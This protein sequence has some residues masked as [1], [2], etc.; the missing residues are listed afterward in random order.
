VKLGDHILPLKRKPGLRTLKA[1][2]SSLR[3]KVLNLLFDKGPQ[4]YTEIMKILRLD[5]SRDAGRFAYHLKYLLKADLIEPD[6]ET[7]EYCIT[8]LGKTVIGFTEDIEERFFRRKKMLVRT[9]R[10]A[11]EE[12]DRNKIAES[13]A[14]EAGVPA[15][16]AQKIARET[17]KRLLEFKTKYLT[18]PLIREIVNS[19]LIKKGLEEYR[20][21]LTRLGLPVFDVTQIIKSTGSKSLGVEVVHK[22]AGDAVIE[23]FTLLN[24]LPRD[25]ADA[26]LSGTLHLNNL[27]SWIL[28]PNEFMH[29]LR[30][31][32]QRGLNLGR[33]DSTG[34]SCLPPKSLESALLTASNALQVAATEISVEQALDFFNIFLAPFAQGLPE[35]RIKKGLRLFVFDLNQSF[36][37]GGFPVA[38]SLGIEFVVPSFLRKREAVG[39]SGKKIG[40][41]ED[42]VEESR[43][44]ASLLLEI[45]FE[46]D[47]HK[48]V[49][50]PSLI[51]KIRPEVLEN[52]EC[53]TLLFQSHKLAAEK[54]LPCFANLCF[55]DQKHASYTAKGCR[56]ASD[57]KRDWEL[58]TL[59]TGNIGKV[60]INLPRTSY[61][62][63][64]K[65]TRFFELL[66]ERLEM[67]LRALEIK[68]RTIKQR[69]G[70]TLLPFLT[71]KAD[72]DNYFKLENASRLVSFVGLSETIESFSGKA[73]HQE[74]ETLSFAEKIVNYLSRNVQ[75]HSKKPE[76]R[77]SLAMVPSVE[78]GRRLAELDAEKY[79]WA[80]VRARGTREQPFYTDMVALP[81]EADV[82]WKERLSIEERFHKITPGGHLAFIELADSEQDP[83]E[84]VA[85]T[86]EIVVTYAVGLYI[87]NR[88][89]AYCAS[90]QKIF[91]GILAKCPSCGSVN[92][93]HCFSR[94]SAK[95]LPTSLLSP[96]RLSA[97]RGRVSY[98]LI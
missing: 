79:G 39:P 37:S 38:A 50:N 67:A 2:S 48:P 12:F 41:Y 93:L 24:V 15:D 14:K 77:T 6:V 20:H 36:P 52:K 1:V 97:L 98:T 58:D 3:L 8:D 78:G 32:L 19:I 89:L 25:I 84:L 63:E 51:M 34:L 55:K 64:G 16:L 9:S 53:A 81:L 87:F 88:R 56:L 59:Q 43:L 73:L 60:S 71:Q 4:S 29:D 42:F 13:L 45:M 5:P 83:N 72:G 49:F 7:K 30:F 35:E 23:E 74:N 47:K 90:C 18:A 40:F 69:A 85:A 82:S 75:K 65:E 96:T 11:I 27:G 54:G 76:T 66:D 17:E 80:K 68:Y 86:K 61:G 94:A 46:D 33:K 95:H 22:A 31:F 44:I 91:Y 10:L 26:H 28:K 21:K 92:M 57:W 70:E 62:A